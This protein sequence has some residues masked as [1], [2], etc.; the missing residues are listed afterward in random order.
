MHATIVSKK[1][2]ED[3]G[4]IWPIGTGGY[5]LKR[6]FPKDFITLEKFEDYWG[7]SLDIREVVF[8]LIEDDEKMKNALIEGEIDIAE[9]ILPKYVDEIS[10][11]Q[12]IK[13]ITVSSPTVVYLS[14][15]FRENNSDTYQGKNPLSDVRVRKAI[16]HA[17][18]VY[19]IIENVK[20]GYAEPAS[21]F[22]SPLIFEQRS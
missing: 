11:T 14:F 16:Y 2:Q 21:Q 5:K 17:I 7:G 9:N 6:Y 4:G 3:T 20:N 1:Y 8:K 19:P 10:N 22:L 18:N 13:V 12:G 15:D